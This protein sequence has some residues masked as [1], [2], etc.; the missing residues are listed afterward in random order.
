MV[1]RLGHIRQFFTQKVKYG[2]SH[3]NWGHLEDQKG[4]F[5]YTVNKL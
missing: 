1:D 3:I 4:L 2:G 5:A